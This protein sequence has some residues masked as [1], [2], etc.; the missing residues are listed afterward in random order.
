MSFPTGVSISQSYGSKLQRL[1]SNELYCIVPEHGFSVNHALLAKDRLSLDERSIFVNCV[2]KDAVRVF[3][4][5]T[6]VAGTRV[7]ISM[8]G[9]VL[10]TLC[11]SGAEN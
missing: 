6:N 8:I 9:E 7:D 3:K 5:P 2:A 1:E 11:S 4:G 10:T